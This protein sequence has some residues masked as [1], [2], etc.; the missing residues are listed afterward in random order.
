MQRQHWLGLALAC[1]T[2]A[3]AC[4]PAAGPAPGPETPRTYG[5]VLTKWLGGDP[6]D[7]DNQTSSTYQT[8]EPFRPAYNGL[9]RFDPYDPQ[10]ERL[11]ADLAER[12]D[13][14]SDG[15]TITFRLRQ[16]VK[17]HEGGAW[18]ARDARFNLERMKD[19]PPG[20]VMPRRAAFQLIERMEVVDDYTLRVVLNQPSPSF[21]P[22]LAQ[23]W[24]VMY[25]RE[26]IEAG[27]NPAKEVNGT[28]P[29]R[30]KEYIR[31]T[32]IE[33]V[34]N[35][36]Y[37]KE[38]YPFLDGVKL[39]I[40]PDQ[41][42]SVAAF[43]TGQLMYYRPNAVNAAAL[44]Q[45]LGDSISMT[46][47][48][49]WGGSFI[50]MSVLT[51]PFDDVRVRR[52]LSLAVDRR[53]AL[54]VLGGG[55]VAGH[56]SA[57]GPW[58]LPPEELAK[59]PGYGTNAEANRAEAKKLLL[60]AG[61]ANGFDT[62]LGVRKVAGAEDPAIFV[63]D[64]WQKIG[65]NA[66]LDIQETAGAYSNLEKGSFGAFIWGTSGGTLDDPDAVYSEY[67]LCSA[68]RNYSRWCNPEVDQ[69]YA[70]QSVELDPAKRKQLV[71][72]MEKKALSQAHLIIV[73]GSQGFWAA[74]GYVRD[75]TPQP[76]VFDNSHLEGVWL[77]KR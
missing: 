33:L 72:E 22:R 52:A 36:S 67:F 5:G 26:W 19:P 59:L 40:I 20:V 15:K 21:F 56:M 38:G 2:V 61:L 42:T 14:S 64:Q 70:R 74:W 66:T 75:Y 18:D 25:D 34:K 51:K 8:N 53:D 1:A 10:R 77:A 41:G 49:G 37:W 30:F 6:P 11:E 35:P 50:N 27:H 3:M 62:K 55:Y 68:P 23:G 12:W 39:L 16:G 45:E 7:F 31:G 13:L 57:P 65:V 4:A 63:K 54:K 44:K 17:F 58:S 24:N 71:W 48:A 46:E 73:N 69:L 76:N 9:I 32:S 43:R 47:T 60:D 29:F 28:G